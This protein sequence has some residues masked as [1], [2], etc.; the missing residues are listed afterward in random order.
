MQPTHLGISLCACALTAA[1][2]LGVWLIDDSAFADPAG[3][4]RPW[5]GTAPAGPG[6]GLALGGG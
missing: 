5:P 4:D 2:S 3:L 6:P 1:L